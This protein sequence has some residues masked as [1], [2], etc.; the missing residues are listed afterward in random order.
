MARAYDPV[1]KR[2]EEGFIG[3]RRKELLGAVGGD[4]LEIGAGTGANFPY[5]PAGASVIAIEPSES[6][7]R[8]AA[9]KSSRSRAN[10]QLLHAGIGDPE[11]AALIP[12]RGLD[13]VVATLVLCTVPD[14]LSALST[15]KGWLKP[16]GRLYLLEHIASGHPAA[17]LAE[18]LINPI[19][20]Q[21]AG[22]CHLTRAT[23][24]LARKAGFIPEWERYYKRGLLF[25]QA[26]MTAPGAV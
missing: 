6:M 5:Y 13:S 22:G 17:R 9:R 16:G 23:D 1:M 26:V 7:L 11:L 14:P 2:T 10:V 12:S 19:W 18:Q 21:I 25:Y 20:K 15:L 24:R 3:R 4:I 8:R